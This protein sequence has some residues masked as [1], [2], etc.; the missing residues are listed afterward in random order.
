[1]YAPIYQTLKSINVLN[2]EFREKIEQFDYEL[3]KDLTKKL[4]G[5]LYK[6][7]RE[8]LTRQL[9]RELHRELGRELQRELNEL[10]G[11]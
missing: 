2:F 10:Y 5:D 3:W 6:A 9:N 8:N 4:R 1:M 11:N 7:L